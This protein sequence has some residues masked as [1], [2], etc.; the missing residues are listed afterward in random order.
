VQ[1]LSR[2]QYWCARH[3]DVDTGTTSHNKREEEMTTSQ[4]TSNYLSR[5]A[6]GAFLAA[7]LIL[8]CLSCYASAVDSKS[9]QKTPPPVQI[10]I[11]KLVW[12]PPPDVPRI[13]WVRLA[14][15]EEDVTGSVSKKKKSSWMDK[16]AG[17]SLPSERGK[18]RL[19]KPYGIAFDSKG[20]IFVAD[21]PQGGVFVFDLEN[22]K[23]E[24]RGVQQ[25]RAPMGLAMDDTDRLFVSDS[26]QHV[27][28][29]FKADGG[30][31]GTFGAD[32]LFKPIGIA[33]DRDNRYLY[34]ADA[35]SNRIA[36]FD[37][38][39][40]KLLRSF[41]GKSDATMAPGTF[42]R[43]TNVAVDDD[44][45]VYITDTFN[46]RVQVF[47]A[48]GQFVRMWGKTGNTAG[49]FMRP[50]GIAVDSDK[51]VYVVDSEF[52]NVQMF[53]SEGHTLMFFGGRGDTPG[54]FTLA[55]GIGFDERTHRVVVSEQWLGRVQVFRYTTDAEAK[56]EYE[57]L[58]KEEEERRAKQEAADKAESD[59]SIAATNSAK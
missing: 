52:N 44:G 41:G 25:L 54:A 17:V 7:T 47:D 58:A 56:P 26:E 48:D 10:D 57:K 53:D 31:E 35:G 42:D 13:K 11:N 38:D 51:H 19:A 34:V 39:N 8:V 12:P 22:K 2:R 43:P 45:N 46:D 27:I 5:R 40:F 4:T 3:V 50:K 32:K 30:L 55:S 18:P 36:V 14:L 23:V 1:P 59:K 6:G 24:Y 15:G 16:M 28:F 9:R 33:L 21:P 49:S 20:R 29:C 37:A